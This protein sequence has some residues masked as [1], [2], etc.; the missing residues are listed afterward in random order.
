MSDTRLTKLLYLVDLYHAE[1]YGRPLTEI[2]FKRYFYGPWSPD[3]SRIKEILMSK[4]VLKEK[5][6]KTQYG[7]IA[8]I[9]KPMLNQVNV[10]LSSE[11]VGVAEAVLNDW[12]NKSTDDIVEY[13]K[14]RPPFVMTSFDEEIDFVK[15]DPIAA[16]AHKWEQ[17]PG[18]AATSIIADTPHLKNLVFMAM[19]QEEE[20]EFADPSE[21]AGLGLPV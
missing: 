5:R 10:Y 7:K 3:I 19:R 16:L 2:K 20:R 1:I 15:A 9:T 4:G 18:G 17:T 8:T 12:D 14:T 13:V 11:A 21:A 6:G